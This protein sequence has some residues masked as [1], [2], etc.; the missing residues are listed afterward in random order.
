VAEGELAGGERRLERERP[1]RVERRQARSRAALEERREER[2]L[3]LLGERQHDVEGRGRQ[4]DH[5]E[6]RR[7]VADERER[8]GRRRRRRPEVR[9]SVEHRVERA[10]GEE[11]DEGQAAR[12]VAAVVEGVE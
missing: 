6:V 8:P 4:L 5:H 2:Q 11:R 12:S 1:D 9:A 10:E 3:A 7:A